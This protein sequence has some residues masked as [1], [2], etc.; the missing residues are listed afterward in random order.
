[1][2]LEIKFIYMHEIQTNKHPSNRKLVGS[3]LKSLWN[4]EANMS[5]EF[6]FTLN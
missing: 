5:K 6:Y 1:M 4:K 2:M 3:I